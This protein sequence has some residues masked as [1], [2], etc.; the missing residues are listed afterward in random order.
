[1]KEEL[2]IANGGS[3]RY[4]TR[5]YKDMVQG[6]ELL[7]SVSK[8]KTLIKGYEMAVEAFEK[9]ALYKRT[10]MQG[11][12]SFQTCKDIYEDKPI[13]SLDINSDVINKG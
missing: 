5:G 6:L 13:N 11:T 4:W 1:M 3:S 12:P 10:F 8:Q 7:R 9:G 2:T